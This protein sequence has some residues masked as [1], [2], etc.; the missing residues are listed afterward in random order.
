MRLRLALVAIF[1]F[2]GLLPMQGQAPVSATHPLLP[3]HIS[4]DLSVNPFQGQRRIGMGLVSKSDKWSYYSR[5][6]NLINASAQT[7]SE[8]WLATECGVKVYDKTKNRV[9][10]F[11]PYDGLPGDKTTAICSDANGSF[12]IQAI[13]DKETGVSAFCAFDRKTERWQSIKQVLHEQTP[14]NQSNYSN[15]FY[16]PG[17]PTV[18]SLSAICAERACFAVSP[19]S[20]DVNTLAYVYDRRLKLW[21]EI[22]VDPSFRKDIPSISLF[23]QEVD[24]DGAWFGT[25]AGLLR[26]HFREKKWDVFLK[27]RMIYAGTVA[28]D[29]S[30]WFTCFKPSLVNRNQIE[31]KTGIGFAS[32]ANAGSWELIH[33]Q[34]KLGTN[35]L[36]PIAALE[37]N[38]NGYSPYSPP[39]ISG[40]GMNKGTVWLTLANR[41]AY[42]VSA[43]FAFFKPDKETFG[44]LRPASLKQ[45]EEIPD[46]A[47]NQPTLPRG[48]LLASIIPTRFPGWTCLENDEMEAIV[49][50]NSVYHDPGKDSDSTRWGTSENSLFHFDAKQKEIERYTVSGVV[51]PAQLATNSLATLD[52][53]LYAQTQQN[54]FAYNFKEPKKEKQWRQIATPRSNWSNSSD[55]RLIPN[56]DSMLIGGSWDALRYFPKT[57]LFRLISSTQ[58]N[59]FKLLGV[60]GIGTWL[61]GQDNRLYLA[62]SDTRIPE[63]YLLANQTKEF[64]L[65]Y[66][67]P[68]PIA[69]SNGRLWFQCLGRDKKSNALAG[70]DPKAKTWTAL[71][72]YEGGNLTQ[73]TTLEA[74]RKTIFSFSFEPK[75]FFSFDADTGE[76]QTALP[77]PPAKYTGSGFSLVSVDD[78]EAWGYSSATYAMVRYDRIKREW[79]DFPMPEAIGSQSI[80]GNLCRKG[81]ALYLGTYQGILTFNILKHEWSRLPG[82][83]LSTVA[84]QV[85]AVDSKSIWMTATP[86]GVSQQNLLRFD[87]ETKQWKTWGAEDGFPENAYFQQ[88]VTDGDACWVRIN[89]GI[90]YRLDPTKDRWENLSQQFGKINAPLKINEVLAD[91]KSTW[92]LP[93]DVYSPDRSLS[94]QDLPILIRH[95]TMSGVYTPLIIP[96]RAKSYAFKMLLDKKSVWTLTVREIYKI[97]KAELKWQNVLQPEL[98]SKITPSEIVSIEDRE[99]DLWL[100]G[101]DRAIRLR[102]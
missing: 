58:G 37:P 79:E 88:I 83:P 94:P 102:K 67:P 80:G 64:D 62:N 66:S 5:G 65:H 3:S 68:V 96:S 2:I 8:T 30:F 19:V 35:K 43:M 41:S 17:S 13:K 21:D 52:D 82:V 26:W 70:Y 22:P 15:Q 98:L 39:S 38:Q 25:N 89:P 51:F 36:Y 92:L 93:T 33:F 28:E 24:R 86:N 55:Q 6:V 91:E 100:V 45:L 56:G 16:S 59:T 60:D 76:W 49:D 48:A 44:I 97:D 90:L 87:R 99:K 18:N 69:Y 47:L 11:T 72:T 53:N 50:S 85:R 1:M 14:K 12:C 29:S 63:I 10:H 84:L 23:W 7:G 42:A 73:L 40:I 20:R 81:E 61:I 95:D 74:G 57:D 27:N 71:K 9:R 46:V 78:K 4:I 101:G 34:P 54:L 75:A 77:M 31:Q 32:A